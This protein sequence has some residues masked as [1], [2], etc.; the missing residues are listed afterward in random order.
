MDQ[1]NLAELYHLPPIP[2]SS[3]LEALEGHNRPDVR[4]FLATT[5]PDGRPH[6]VFRDDG[7]AHQ[8]GT[9]AGDATQ[10]YTVTLE[11]PVTTT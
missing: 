8:L 3:V 5:R 2:W 10:G 11:V 1:K 9:V 4:C 7:A 6:M